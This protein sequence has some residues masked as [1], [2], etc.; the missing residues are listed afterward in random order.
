MKL[1]TTTFFT[2]LLIGFAGGSYGHG[3]RLNTEGCHNQNSDGTYHCHRGPLAGQSFAN[4]AEADSRVAIP[5]VSDSQNYRR[6]DYLISWIDEDGDCQ[7]LRHEMLIRD[8]LS[9]ITF[10][11]SNRCTV[12]AGRWLDP[13]TGIYIDQASDLDVDH[14]IPLAYAH[15]I[16]GYNWSTNKKHNFAVD[17]ANL[18]L[19]DDGENQSKGAKGPSEYLPRKEFQC[20]YVRIW[21]LVAT[22]YNLDLLKRDL[23]AIRN[24]LTQC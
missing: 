14:V 19:V 12:T 10:T 11:N 5:G 13:Y 3:G 9:D 23:G 20:E 21:Q 24:I 22:K 2:L 6:Q 17:E 8:T 16:G 15:R 18:L 4:R 1:L 7:N